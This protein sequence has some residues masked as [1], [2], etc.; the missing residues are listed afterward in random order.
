MRERISVTNLICLTAVI[1]HFLLEKKTGLILR[2][3]G[4][5]GIE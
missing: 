5:N 2:I 1:T 3:D 4:E